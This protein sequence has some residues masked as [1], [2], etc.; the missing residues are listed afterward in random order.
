MAAP[1]KLIKN[2]IEQG[3]WEMVCKGYEALTGDELTPPSF[4]GDIN[5]DGVINYLQTLLTKEEDLQVTS[6]KGKKTAKPAT[7]SKQAAPVK[8]NNTIATSRI[9]KDSESEPLNMNKL[10][11]VPLVTGKVGGNKKMFLPAEH[12]YNKDEAEAWKECSRDDEPREAYKPDFR[13]C[14][15]GAKYD[16]NKVYPGGTID[17]EVEPICEK[18]L[19]KRSKE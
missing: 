11:K 16:F 12:L 13:K 1:L 10:P 5:L 8:K 17:K 3:N 7:K 9:I 19:N 2:G 6:S 18:C 15:C 4:K 14:D